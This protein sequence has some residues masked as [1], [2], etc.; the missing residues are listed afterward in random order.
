MKTKKEKSFGNPKSFGDVNFPKH[1]TPKIIHSALFVH[2]APSKEEIKVRVEYCAKEI[3]DEAMSFAMALL[4]LPDLMES[5]QRSPEYKA[6]Q[7]M[8]KKKLN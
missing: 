4:V 5:T 3:G 8:K 6:W 1:L 7:E 2:N